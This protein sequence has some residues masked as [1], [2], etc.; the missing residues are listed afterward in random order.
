MVGGEAESSAKRAR[1]PPARPV[2][3][4]ECWDVGNRTTS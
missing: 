4:L 2:V 3:M 1:S